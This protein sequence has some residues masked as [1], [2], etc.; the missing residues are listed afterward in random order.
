MASDRRVRLLQAL[1]QGGSGVPLREAT[2]LI[3]EAGRPSERAT[4]VMLRQLRKERL[5]AYAPPAHGDEFTRGGLYS[6]TPEGLTWLEDRGFDPLG[7]PDVE[8]IT[9]A[10]QRDRRTV[11]LTVAVAGQVQPGTFV[12]SVFDLAAAHQAPQSA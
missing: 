4:V 10:M 1:A 3:G 7:E 11:V 2:L 12:T 8:I 9:G 5:A 6:I